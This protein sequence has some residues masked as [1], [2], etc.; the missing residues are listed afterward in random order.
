MSA[1][2]AGS[3][4]TASPIATVAQGAEAACYAS[5]VHDPSK[6]P[7]VPKNPHLN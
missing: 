2:A 7:V 3:P 5:A 4:T 6:T 1:A